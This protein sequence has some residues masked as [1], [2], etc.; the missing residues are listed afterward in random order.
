MLNK[1]HGLLEDVCV[2]YNDSYLNIHC[3]MAVLYASL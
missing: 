2:P 3:K 1:I